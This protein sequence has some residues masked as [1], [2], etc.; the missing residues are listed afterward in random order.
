[1]NE[2]ENINLLELYVESGVNETYGDIAFN[3]YEEYNKPI[4][5][6]SKKFEEEYKLDNNVISI[7]EIKEKAQEISERVNT[8][9]EL[10]KEIQR[11]EYCPLKSKSIST[12]Y[13][14]GKKENPKLLVLTEIPN[15][16]EDKKGEAYIGDTGD[17]LKNILKAIDCSLEEN[18]YAMPVMFYR[19]AGGRAPTNEE[20][21]T[22][23]PFI[24][25]MIDILCPQII[26]TFGGVPSTLL[27]KKEENITGLRGKWQ[28]YKKIAL[29]PTFSLQ[30]IISSTKQGI[31]EVKQKVWEDVK[32][33]KQKLTELA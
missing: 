29:M 27:L 14:T 4:K 33:V 20:M 30:Y 32:E 28:E 13:G 18:T 11:F 16:E 24:Y 26:L 23:S 25:K 9:D 12:I 8:I 5:N 31:K 17:L 22:I 19:P 3:F 2:I 10:I 7:K 1:M 6:I 15:A 21:E